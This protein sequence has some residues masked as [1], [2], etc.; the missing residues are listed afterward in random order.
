MQAL[1]GECVRALDRAYPDC[2][3]EAPKIFRIYRDVRFAKDK[4]PYKTHVGGY[5]PMHGK[6]PIGSPIALYVQVGTE[7]FAGA[8][9]YS[10]DGPS[11]AKFRA[12]VLDPKRGAE[13]GRMLAKLEP[14]GYRVSAM[15]TL[16]KV[17]KG[18]DPE[19]PR[20]ELLKHK[21]LVLMFPPVPKGL[22]AKRALLDWAVTHARAVAPVVRW[23][24]FATA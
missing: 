17:P 5:L 24:V 10:M 13:L 4:S 6:S 20:A 22:I 1:L 9:Q 19:H 12:A 3:L 7:V 23:L 15:E 11:L 8:G 18:V 14:K 21:G 16:K 2:E